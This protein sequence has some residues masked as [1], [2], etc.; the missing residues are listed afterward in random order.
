MREPDMVDDLVDAI[1][2][3]KMETSKGPVSLTVRCVREFGTDISVFL[4]V[5]S[6]KRPSTKSD[7]CF[8]GIKLVEDPTMRPHSWRFVRPVT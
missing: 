8:M 3:V 5:Y 7:S 1:R 2:G 6:G 4:P